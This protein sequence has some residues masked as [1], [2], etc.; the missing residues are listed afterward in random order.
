MVRKHVAMVLGAIVIVAAII[1]SIIVSAS[2]SHPVAP[3]SRPATSS[4][5]QAL[6]ALHADANGASVSSE[7]E[8]LQA[9]QRLKAGR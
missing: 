2:T 9:L 4:Q 1:V 5:L 3:A 8:K 7:D 6:Q